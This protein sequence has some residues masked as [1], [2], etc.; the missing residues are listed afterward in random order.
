MFFKQPVQVPITSFW[1]PCAKW[2]G[3]DAEWGGRDQMGG[4]SPEQRRRVEG[5]GKKPRAEKL[6]PVIESLLGERWWAPRELAAVL[7]RDVGSLVEDPS[8]P[9]LTYRTVIG[10]LFSKQKKDHP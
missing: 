6:R 4:L 2:G 1:R 7:H 10:P 5:L 9:A 3:L 8:H